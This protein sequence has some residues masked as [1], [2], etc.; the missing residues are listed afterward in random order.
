MLPDHRFEIS[1]VHFVGPLQNNV[2]VGRGGV[3]I[4]IFLPY[5]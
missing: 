4:T 1:F 5:Q 2:F 3:V